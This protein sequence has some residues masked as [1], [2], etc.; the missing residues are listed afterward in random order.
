[1]AIIDF[2]KG[3][4]L[5]FFVVVCFFGISSVIAERTNKIECYE[6]YIQDKV[7]IKK[8]QKYFD[9]LNEKES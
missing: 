9:K 7:I 3:A 1:M 8:C 5:S 6:T 4:I 2:I